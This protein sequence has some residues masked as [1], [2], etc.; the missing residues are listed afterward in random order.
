MFKL[1][2]LVLGLAIGFGGGV[3]WG[4]KNPQAAAN[5]SSQEEK[6]FLQAQLAMNQKIKSKLDQLQSGSSSK[7]P[8]SGFLGTNPGT[9]SVSDVKADAEK[10]EADLQ[11]RLAKLK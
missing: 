5:F 9:P 10:Q 11:A 6:E 7:T 3:W 2:I 1:I 4:Q 8:G